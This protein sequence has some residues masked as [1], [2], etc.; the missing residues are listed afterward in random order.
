[1]A[2]SIATN[3]AAVTGITTTPTKV[4][5]TAYSSETGSSP[6][7]PQSGYFGGIELDITATAGSPA[8][9]SLYL[10]WDTGGDHFITVTKTITLVA[11][12]TTTPG[13]VKY[14]GY[15]AIDQWYRFPSLWLT[16]AGTVYAWVS[17][18]AG[19]VTVPAGSMRLVA[20]NDYAGI[21]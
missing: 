13:A 16:A 7:I 6:A 17:F 20:T 8:T 11:G 14:G 19:T 4:P 9:A 5:L 21:Q 1:M 3:T 2:T 10:T 15:A 12:Q 18:N